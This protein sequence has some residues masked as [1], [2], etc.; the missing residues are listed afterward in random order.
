MTQ[1]H[2][3][4]AH[5]ATR[6]SADFSGTVQW[7]LT[8]A[9]SSIKHLL[10][11]LV[12]LPKS[13]IVVKTD[14]HRIGTETLW[15]P[16]RG[17]TFT[18]VSSEYYK[19]LCW[20]LNTLGASCWAH[21]MSTCSHRSIHSEDVWRKCLRE[22]NPYMPSS[23][24]MWHFWWDTYLQ[25]EF[26]KD[27]SIIKNHVHGGNPLFLI[28]SHFT[29]SE[30]AVKCHFFIPLNCEPH[31]AQVNWAKDLLSLYTKRLRSGSLLIF[32]SLVSFSCTKHS[33]KLI[34]NSPLSTTFSENSWVWWIS[35]KWLKERSY[36]S[37]C[38]SNYFARHSIILSWH[39]SY[40]QFDEISVLL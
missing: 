27:S 32:K 13:S 29:C 6:I 7:E 40:L 4:V 22:A 1:W 39:K 25:K 18:G 30:R 36:F 24:Q 10:C 12:C 11:S 14:L 15:V 33:N 35:L 19:L 26:C 23:N 17:K 16:S 31:S 37:L 2:A 21:S 20:T 9:A 8:R 34:K 28:S 5:S 3:N 38:R